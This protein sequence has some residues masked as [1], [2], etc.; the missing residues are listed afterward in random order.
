[1]EPVEHPKRGQRLAKEG[2]L[3][4]SGLHCIVIIN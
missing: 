3:V 1:V 2:W 4:R